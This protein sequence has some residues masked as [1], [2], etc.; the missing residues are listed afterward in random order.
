[1]RMGES[2]V[3]GQVPVAQGPNKGRHFPIRRAAEIRHIAGDFGV[4]IHAQTLLSPNLDTRQEVAR[5]L[6][7]ACGRLSLASCITKVSQDGRIIQKEERYEEILFQCRCV[8]H[9][10]EI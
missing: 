2:D 3:I 8:S 6:A 10:S 7:V 1:M 9:S 5:L 4:C